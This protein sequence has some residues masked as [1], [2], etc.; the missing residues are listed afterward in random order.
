MWGIFLQP[1]HGTE[2]C[3]RCSYQPFSRALIT[4][5]Q[6]QSSSSAAF[7]L[8]L[9]NLTIER[10]GFRYMLGKSSSGSSSDNFN[11]HSGCYWCRIRRLSCCMLPTK[12]SFQGIHQN[13]KPL[14]EC[15]SHGSNHPLPPIHPCLRRC[16][17]TTVWSVC[18]FHRSRI[19]RLLNPQ[20]VQV[21]V[22][23]S[24]DRIGGRVLTDHSFGF[25]VDMGA[26]W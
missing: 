15:P 12:F 25:P 22:L 16:S 10:Y 19:P 3:W 24:R 8:Y 18:H 7:A 2:H 1:G 6:Q 17:S 23:E 4:C 11:P 14:V 20:T 26:S 9:P 13:P 5:I 21:V